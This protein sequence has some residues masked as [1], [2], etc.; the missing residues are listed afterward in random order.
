MAATLT[1]QILDRAPSAVVAMDERGRVT[2]WNPGAEDMFGFSRDAAVGRTVA[3]LIIP[4]RYH[5]AHIAGLER[6][7]AECEQLG[8]EIP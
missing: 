4:E 7:L 5:A 2:Y 6:F 1:E 8:D 3:E